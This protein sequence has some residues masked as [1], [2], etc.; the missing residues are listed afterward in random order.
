M[1][2]KPLPFDAATI[3]RIVRDFPTPVYVYD[4]RGI[5]AGARRLKAAFDWC[6][7][8]KEFF[9]VKATPNPHILQILKEEGF[10][11][12]CSSLGELVLCERVGIV[13]EEIMFTSNETPARDY[14]KAR[15]L[16]AIINLDDITHVA[17]LEQHVGLPELISFRYNPGPLRQGNVIIGLPQE[18]K[19]GLTRE[20]L[21]EGY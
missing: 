19:Y 7:R 16:G 3:E 13:G 8:F 6:E 10:G 12:D 5:R 4:E 1:P 9:A 17:Y 11:A 18:A 14:A 15:E 2:A 21:F 20:Q